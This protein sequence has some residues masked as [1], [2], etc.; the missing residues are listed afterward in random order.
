MANKNPLDECPRCGNSSFIFNRYVQQEMT[1]KFGDPDSLELVDTT[2]VES[3]KGKTVKCSN[4][5]YRVS[6]TKAVGNQ[7]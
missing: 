2:E 4:C 3:L 6:K 7:L 5:D 1:G